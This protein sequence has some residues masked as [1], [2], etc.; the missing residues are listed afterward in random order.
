MFLVQGMAV[1]DEDFF[2][3]W[4]RSSIVAA[5]LST[6]NVFGIYTYFGKNSTVAAFRIPPVSGMYIS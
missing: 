1:L 5:N 2:R 4:V 3:I 6:D